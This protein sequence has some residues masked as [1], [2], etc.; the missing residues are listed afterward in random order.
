MKSR[1]VVVMALAAML[2]CSSVTFGADVIGVVTALQNEV[3]GVMPAELK[4]SFLAMWHQDRFL[5]SRDDGASM[6]QTG[7]G[8]YVTVEGPDMVSPV[9]GYG[10]GVVNQVAYVTTGAYTP[11]G[12]NT[13]LTAAFG[14]LPVLGE[15]L[16]VGASATPVAGGGGGL[17]VLTGDI[18]VPVN[19]VQ[20]QA[21][22]HEDEIV[23]RTDYDFGTPGDYN[24]DGVVN[25]DSLASAPAPGDDPSDR[26]F[27]AIYE[28]DGT[29][30][31]YV[32]TNEPGFD[33]D[34]DGIRTDN[35]WVGNPYVSV[36]A[37]D[38]GG[39][40]NGTADADPSIQNVNGFGTPLLV[41]EIVDMWLENTIRLD[42]DEE[43]ESFIR[44]SGFID[45]KIVGGRL[46]DYIRTFTGYEDVEYVRSVLNASAF[47]DLPGDYVNEYEWT[48]NG[49]LRLFPEAAPI[50]EPGSLSLLLGGVALA[51]RRR[52]K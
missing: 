21:N 15:T 28:N 13:K 38:F 37:I 31:Q 22:P 35:A 39:V 33:A 52:R 4:L 8:G 2:L 11:I 41:G 7:N 12:F 5:V 6:I 51:F 43:S 40:F 27:I 50:A 16:I 44:S 30:P 42:L 25:W 48:D 23:F 36:D 26:P 47:F 49:T 18:A 10:A 29:G 3:P 9:M 32:N 19:A 24:R 1:F 45:V 20:L 46:L 17:D 14:N 34:G